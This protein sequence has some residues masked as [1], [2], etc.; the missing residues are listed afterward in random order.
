[1]AETKIIV[2]QSPTIKANLNPVAT[3]DNL[4]NK[5]DRAQKDITQVRGGMGGNKRIR[6]LTG[7]VSAGSSDASFASFTATLS[8]AMSA[9]DSLTINGQALTGV[10]SAPTA[11]QFIVGVSA[12]ADAASLAAC[13]NNFAS[14]SQ[15]VVGIVNASSSAGVV[16]ISCNLPGVIGNLITCTKSSSAVTLSGLTSNS[17]TN[18]SGGLPVLKSYSFG[19]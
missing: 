4:L 11:N 9:G 10:L 5:Y 18:G 2:I 7:N 17:P 1:M 19:Y 14:T 8:G 13:I 16:S 3:S 12:S 15:S 6:Y